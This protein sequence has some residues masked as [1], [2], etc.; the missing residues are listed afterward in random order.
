MSHNIELKLAVIE[1]TALR[2][3]LNEIAHAKPQ[4]TRHFDGPTPDHEL[5]ATVL[6]AEF[7][8]LQEIASMALNKGQ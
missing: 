4:V 1:L 7:D 6:E 3:A 8:S 2:R 5:D